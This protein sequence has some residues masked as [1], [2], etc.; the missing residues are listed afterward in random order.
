MLFRCR[1]LVFP[2]CRLQSAGLLM[3]IVTL[4]SFPGLGA[5]AIGNDS[6]ER[7][8]ATRQESGPAAGAAG[9]GQQ[10]G[11]G[12]IQV[13]SDPWAARVNGFV[14]RAA[15]VERSLQRSRIAGSPADSGATGTKSGSASSSLPG[16]SGPGAQQPAA[17][18]QGLSAPAVA[19]ETP[20]PLFAATLEHLVE[21]QI[22][23][24]GLQKSPDAVGPS[25][26]KL[27]IQN[28]EKQ[29]SE[30]GATLDQH[31]A[32]QGMSRDEF[33]SALR[34]KLAWGGH[35]ARVITEESA[36]QYFGEH[37]SEFDGTGM[38]V[39]QVLWIRDPAA[40]EEAWQRM[41]EEAGQVARQV[42]GGTLDW[43][44]AVRQHSMSP[45]AREDEEAR[46]SWISRTGPMPE[47]FT[48]AA[49]RLQPGEISSL[50]ES[51]IGLHLIRC[52]ESKQGY[53][54][55]S[56]VRGAVRR[57]MADRLFREWVERER[58]TARIEYN[59]DYPHFDGRGQLV[60]PQS[61]PQN[62]GG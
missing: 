57:S 25:Q 44:A 53:R 12:K 2:A 39:D 10:T 6:V 18:R 37:R 51:P 52:L 23:L 56:E 45:L 36:E 54:K 32:D 30:S 61:L 46:I 47:A 62:G 26:L 4:G 3:T 33:E 17:D 50:V 24:G 49:F 28:L 55:Y 11:H 35:L 40:G 27:E 20:A 19:T 9:E 16:E 1:G 13:S 43:G 41:R 29:L 34:W 7:P 48:T 8:P 21:Q 59:P 42:A 60:L 58:P 5:S 14:I 22:V 38:A 31:L 15:V